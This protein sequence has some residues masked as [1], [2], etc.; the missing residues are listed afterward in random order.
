[1]SFVSNRRICFSAVTT[2]FIIIVVS[3][4]SFATALTTDRVASGLTNP[5]FAT[6]PPGDDRL[7]ILEQ[8]GVIKI[9]KTG[10]VLATPFLD[11]STDVV[12]GGERGLLGLAFAPDYQTS[13]E[14]YVDYTGSGG[15][16]YIMRFHVSG[17]PDVADAASGETIL[18]IPQPQTNHNG[19]MLAFSPNDGYLYVGLGDG[20]A[21]GDP[22]GLIGNGQDSTTLYGSILR[23]DV[24][25]GGMGY[26]VPLTNPLIATP[27]QDEI[28]AFGFRN[29]WRFSFDRATGDLYIGDVGEATYEEIDFQPASST[30]GENY[31]WRLKE[32]LHCY[33]P[34]VACDP[35]GL[36]DPILE[37]DHTD[38]NAVTGGYVYRGCQIPDLRGTYFYAD[39]GSARIFSFSYDGSTK[40]DST[41]RTT[42]L[43]PTTG[44][45][46]DLIS[47]FAE[48]A[49]GELYI[50]DY[51][52]G[53]IYKIIAD[54]PVLPDCAAGCCVIAG[55]VNDDGAY[56]IS[57]GVYIINNVFKGGPDPT[58]YTT[59]DV[60][61][62]GAYNISDAVHI[63]N[64]VFKGGSGPSCS[65]TCTSGGC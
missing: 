60:N 13:G 38:G 5:T 19:G 8:G 31:G 55:D 39:Y 51:L 26:G 32:G 40:S 59:A 6:S 10:S 36:T 52:D 22:H 41:E 46:I 12:S 44:M 65:S 33:N 1:M 64:N 23:L 50:V 48:D 35:G 11:I 57:D 29:P 61:D 27:G 17:D 43:A 37:Y 14:F 28:W 16:T 2:L 47:S 62:D 56:N 18:H 21:A 34:P 4:L 30:G 54:E 63:I 7:F 58:C 45:S 49:D 3:R 25:G 9:L 15:D 20:G 42:E 24:S 53:E